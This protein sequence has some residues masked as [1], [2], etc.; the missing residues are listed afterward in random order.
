MTPR[1]V[2]ALL[3][4]AI[5]VGLYFAARLPE[6]TPSERADLAARFRFERLELR[7]PMDPGEPVQSVRRVH[8]SFENIDGW[9]S[10]VGA[11]VAL[12]DLDGDGLAND[13][14]WVDP[15]YDRVF[16]APAP[17]TPVRY[18][19]FALDLPALDE[20]LPTWA[21]M[22][23]LPGDLNEDGRLDLLITFWGRTPLALLRTPGERLG[24]DAFRAQ[25]VCPVNERWYSNAALLSDVD[26]D[27]HA[28]LIVGNYFPDGAAVLDPD[29][30]GVESM[31]HSMSRAFNGGTDRILRWTSATKGPEPTV[32]FREVSGA[33]PLPGVAGWTLA[34][35]A[36]DLDG[37]LLPELYFAHDFGPDLFLHNRSV[38]GDVRLVA[39]E[40]ERGLS[41]PRSA[42]VGQDSFKGMGVDFGDLNGDGH[43]D[44]YVSNITCEFGLEESQLLFLNTGDTG[45]LSRGVAPFADASE[46]LGL[47]R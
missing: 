45:A 20:E 40:G 33:L 8:P 34:I 15:R 16:V 12:N 37:D 24:A 36:A 9:I 3:G 17:G 23:C 47:S 29:G 41:T 6:P 22:G 18:T 21:P 26:G 38:A 32:T 19:P 27:G 5:C 31:Q 30:T 13:V 4:L 42:V 35:A 10:S 28:D 7:T 2:K 25:E 11:A 1:L 39:V 44:L 14:C 43:L 46:E